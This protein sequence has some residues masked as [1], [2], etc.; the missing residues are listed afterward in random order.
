M[1]QRNAKGRF[2]KGGGGKSR[3]GGSSRGSTSSRKSKHEMGVH[4]VSGT[5]G[6]LLIVDGLVA[7]DWGGSFS[8]SPIGR[9]IYTKSPSSALDGLVGNVTG[10]SNSANVSTQRVKTGAMLVIGGKIVGWLIPSAKKV[11][12]FGKFRF[13]M[14]N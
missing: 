3:R 10:L 6:G 9:L 1:P 2:V 5:G 11:I 14:V 12:R 4:S 13:R 7:T 8:D